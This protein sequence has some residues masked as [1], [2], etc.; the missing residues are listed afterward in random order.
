MALEQRIYPSQGRINLTMVQ[1]TRF[2]LNHA[3]FV[4]WV[5]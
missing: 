3:S 2:M 4:G 5:N 1:Y